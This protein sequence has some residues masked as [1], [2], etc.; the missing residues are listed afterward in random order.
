MSKHSK[1]NEEAMKDVDRHAEGEESSVPLSGSLEK[2]AH[3]HTKPVGDQRE[4]ELKEEANRKI[5]RADQLHG[6][7]RN[8]S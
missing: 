5:S 1:A 6:G 3:A 7:N 8:R 2:T 4:I